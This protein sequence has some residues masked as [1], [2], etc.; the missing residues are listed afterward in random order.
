MHKW[1][2]NIPPGDYTVKELMQIANPPQAYE[3][4]R[5]QLLR[6][7]VESYRR[8]PTE[9]NYNPRNE[10]VWRWKGAAYY[11]NNHKENKNG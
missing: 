10:K 6:F 1:Y 5:A 7:K 8:N 4:V 2:Y 3:C 11:L 9:V